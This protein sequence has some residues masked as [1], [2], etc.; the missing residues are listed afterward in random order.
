MFRILILIFS[1]IN[2][3][4][5]PKEWPKLNGWCYQVFESGSWERSWHAAESHCQSRGGDL[6][7]IQA[8][9]AKIYKNFQ[10]HSKLKKGYDHFDKNG[11]S[12]KGHLE[13][14]SLLQVVHVEI[15]HMENSLLRKT[16]VFKIDHIENGPLRRIV[17][18][19]IDHFEKWLIF[20]NDRFKVHFR[21]E[22][23]SK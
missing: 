17:H 11:V 1:A 3:G 18:F 9:L 15:D 12:S 7:D 6:V 23:Y 10:N 2:A 22:S 5:C 14:R 8:Q 4:N 20:R 16:F 21:T 13:K 19:E